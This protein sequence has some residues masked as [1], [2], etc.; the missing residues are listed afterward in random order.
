VG[1]TM[2]CRGACCAGGWGY[3]DL[4][5]G[6]EGLHVVSVAEHGK[7]LVVTVEPESARTAC[8]ACGVI[9][10]RHGRREVTDRHPVLRPAGASGVA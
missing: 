9:G 7:W 3:C 5:V 1:E 10:E 8:G 4:L 6:L 2:T